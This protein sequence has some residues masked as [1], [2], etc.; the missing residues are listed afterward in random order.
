MRCLLSL[1]I[2]HHAMWR[3]KRSTRRI[4]ARYG[5]RLAKRLDPD[6][7]MTGLFLGFFDPISPII[8]I[9]ASFALD[10]VFARFK[11]GLFRTIWTAFSEGDR[12]ID[13][14]MGRNPCFECI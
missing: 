3:P 5:P 9:I 13:G 8:A 4:G 6:P 2:S 7:N 12:I 11:T 1:M 14:Q 10:V